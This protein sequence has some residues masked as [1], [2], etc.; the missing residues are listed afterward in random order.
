MTKFFKL[1]FVVSYTIL[2]LILNFTSQGEILNLQALDLF[3]VGHPP[4]PDIVILAI[5]N[6]SLQNIGRWPWS[7]KTHAQIIDK[8]SEVDPQTLGIDIIF[9]ESESSEADILFA[10]SL[11]RSDFKIILASQAV[12]FRNSDTQKIILPLQELLDNPNVS[13]GLV[14]FDADIDGKVRSFPKVLNISGEEFLP[15]S[16]KIA[17][18]INAQ[19]PTHKKRLI[20]LVGKSGSFPTYSV[21]DLLEDK[22]GKEELE[23]KIILMGATASDLHDTVLIAN[24]NPVMAGI[25]L[26]ANILDNLLLERSIQFLPSIIPAILGFLVG[27]IYLFFLTK[28]PVKKTSF[29]LIATAL[30]FPLVS[31]ILWQMNL[32]LVYLTGLLLSLMIFVFHTIYS[33][34]LAEAEKRKIKSTFSPYFSPSVMEEILK[35]P[36]KLRLGGQKKEVSIMFSDIRSFTTISESLEP[37]RLT[38]LLHEYFT[39][40]TKEILATDGVLDKFIGDAI[41]AFWGA[42]I[43]QK[44]HADRALKSAINMSRR[45]Q[46]LQKKWLEAGFPIIQ[47]GYGISS[48]VVTVG[49][50]GSEDRFDYT[51]IGD[52][53]NLASRLEGTTKE[54]K[55]N[56]II[57][58]ST[59]NKLTRKVKTASLG[60]VTVKGKLKPVKI[61]KVIY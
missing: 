42:P 4:H 41:M 33:W 27:A 26:N 1:F 5:D 2:L 6:K 7:R 54:F 9:A 50:M 52:D 48:G 34:Y 43:E 10:E 24:R 46:K 13:S 19:I 15:F 47:A 60:E 38:E 11:K 59:K 58:Q 21:I 51:V 18:G 45:L 28:L 30:A 31:F 57:S 61:Y 49:N 44:D 25:E 56:I 53:V 39:Q 20:D 14:N 22:I 3:Q 36:D 37:E 29:M 55:T 16:F 8:L 35:D 17:K 12:F 32:A 23:G 40:M